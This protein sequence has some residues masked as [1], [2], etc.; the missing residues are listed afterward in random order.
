[1]DTQILNLKA[2]YDYIYCNGEIGKHI[3][4]MIVYD[5]ATDEDGGYRLETHSHPIIKYGV[6]PGGVVWNRAELTDCEV[7]CNDDDKRVNIARFGELA[8]AYFRLMMESEDT[9]EMFLPAS[10]EEVMFEMRDKMRGFGLGFKSPREGKIMELYV[11]ISEEDGV[12]KVRGTDK[13]CDFRFESE[14]LD[15]LKYQL[16]DKRE[17]WEYFYD[18][19]VQFEIHSAFNPE[20]DKL[21]KGI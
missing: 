19:A 8:D 13:F 20:Y 3:A 4:T 1:M 15:E 16:A 10:R 7:L 17:Y 6:S 14:S 18:N 11:D 5:V 21:L 2:P 12:F 9:D